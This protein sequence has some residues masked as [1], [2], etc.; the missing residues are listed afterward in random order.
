MHF[1]VEELLAED[2]GV[3]AEGHFKHL[4]SPRG[5]VNVATEYTLRMALSTSFCSLIIRP[6]K[7]PKRKPGRPP[8]PDPATKL[9]RF[10]CTPEEL[11]G[12]HRTA[13]KRGTK[14][15]PWL[16][17]LADKDVADTE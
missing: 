16:K 12:Y 2:F 8:S 15:S 9:A 4:V 13:A 3:A 6:M 11:A 1:Y 14:L 17:A 10:R 5:L 7:K